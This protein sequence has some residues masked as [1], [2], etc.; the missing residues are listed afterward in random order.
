MPVILEQHAQGASY[1]MIW[2]PPLEDGSVEV[3]FVHGPFVAI[4]QL[5][6]FEQVEFI[7]KPDP[8]KNFELSESQYKYEK[9]R[10]CVERLPG[11]RWTPVCFASVL[12]PAPV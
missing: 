11:F 4:G 8:G 12:A 3:T 2:G 6:N 9:M 5:R 1:A 10:H 7:A